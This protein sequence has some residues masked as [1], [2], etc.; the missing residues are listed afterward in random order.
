MS[1][2]A[3]LPLIV[4]VLVGLLVLTGAVLT[5]IGSLGLVR[6]GDFYERLHAPTLGTSFGMACV[7]LGSVLFFSVQK[8][9]PVVH[10]VLIG[11]LVV[12]TTPVT[13]MLLGRAALHRDRQEGNRRVPA[14]ARP[15]RQPRA[16]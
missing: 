5:L 7:L 6:L 11:L 16:P 15:T 13:L 1:H 12:T 10:E 14:S 2:A 4:A 9:R 3:E 8:G